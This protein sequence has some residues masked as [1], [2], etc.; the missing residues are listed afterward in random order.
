MQYVFNIPGGDTITPRVNFGH[1]S[2]QNATLFANPAFG[3]ILE[4]RNIWNGQ[5]EWRHDDLTV[6]L[7]GTNL[8]DQHYVAAL[9]AGLRY[10]G[11]PQQYGIR[12][13]RTF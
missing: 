3:D 7:Y 10:A 4:A 13:M 9:R 11:A 6:T 5:L 12:L 1:V 8:S 2:E